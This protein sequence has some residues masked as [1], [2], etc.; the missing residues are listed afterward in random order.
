MITVERVE[1]SRAYPRNGN[2]QP[3]IWWAVRIDGKLAGMCDTK[4]AAEAY[5][6]EL[7]EEETA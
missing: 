7:R 1:S 6:S 2:V 4:K 5:A 3:T